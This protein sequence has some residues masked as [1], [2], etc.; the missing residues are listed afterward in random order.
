MSNLKECKL[1]GEIQAVYFLPIDENKFHGFTAKEM[2]FQIE[3]ALNKYRIFNRSNPEFILMHPGAVKFIINEYFGAIQ[4][5]KKR[6]YKPQMFGIPIFRT[7]D[8][9]P[10]K[11]VLK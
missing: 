1:K 9:N 7:K 10:T 5:T 3:I 6:I 2:V 4:T 8:I 11:A